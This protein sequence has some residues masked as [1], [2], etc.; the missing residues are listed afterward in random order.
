MAARMQQF[1]YETT[2]FEY[3]EGGHGSGTTPAQT[4]YTWAFIYTWFARA[5][6]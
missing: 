2:Y 3:T 6:M 4:A 1:G 5:L